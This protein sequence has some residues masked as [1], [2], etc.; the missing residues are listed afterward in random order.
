MADRYTI[1][2]NGKKIFTALSETEY[3]DIMDDFAVEYYK[4]GR[5]TPA[6]LETII[7]GESKWQ[8]QKSDS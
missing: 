5:P 1:L 8:K 6:E 7:I 2:R 4:T 3:F